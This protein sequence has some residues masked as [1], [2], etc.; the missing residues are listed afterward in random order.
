LGNFWATVEPAPTL[1]DGWM[2]E[3]MNGKWSANSFIILFLLT[4]NDYVLFLHEY[5]WVLSNKSKVKL[6]FGFSY[7]LW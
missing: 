4:Q 7:C 3:W 2:D 5:S 6:G 1:N